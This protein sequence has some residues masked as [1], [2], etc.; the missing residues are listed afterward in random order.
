MHARPAEDAHDHTTERSSQIQSNM[1][2]APYA[3]FIGLLQSALYAWEHAG[4]RRAAT[5]RHRWKTTTEGEEMASG[6]T[7]EYPSALPQGNSIR[8]KRARW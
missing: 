8:W 4:Q 5:S 2:S 3:T 1:A 7:S 6:A